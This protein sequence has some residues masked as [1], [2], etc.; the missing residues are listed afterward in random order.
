M[1]CLSLLQ[2]IFPTQR[3][4][5]GLLPCRRIL[6]QL[7]HK[8]SPRI[9]EWVACPLSRGSSRPRN[10]TRISCIAGGFFTNCAMREA[11]GPCWLSILHT[12]VCICLEK[13]VATHSSNS[14]LE[15][16]MERGAWWA[17]V[18]GVAKSRTRLT[19][20]QSVYTVIPAS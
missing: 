18:H 11:P 17:A 14:C 4:N 13:E 3:L 19:H 7:N 10:Q 5:S 1:G 16:F 2:G 8:G 20:T 15:N 6:Y 12:V 9:L